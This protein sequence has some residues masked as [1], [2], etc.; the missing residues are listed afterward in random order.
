MN[1]FHTH[2]RI[3]ADYE[4]YIRSFLKIADPQIREAVENELKKGKLWPEPLLQSLFRERLLS[5]EALP[6]KPILLVSLKEVFNG[7]I[8]RMVNGE[9][10]LDPGRILGVL[11]KESL[12]LT[13]A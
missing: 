6:R 8:L 4:T 5:I 3:V 2:S 1:V 13:S 11:K 12:A 7:L 10:R 9:R